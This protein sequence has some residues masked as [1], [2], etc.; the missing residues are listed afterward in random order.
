MGSGKQSD[1]TKV[2]GGQSEGE[3]LRVERKE[4]GDREDRRR[5]THTEVYPSSK[6]QQRL[7]P[8]LWVVRT[9]GG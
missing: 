9:N 4:S 7:E 8:M 6:L 2:N 3:R 5:F 1:I